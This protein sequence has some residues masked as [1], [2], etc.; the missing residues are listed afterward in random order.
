LFN[1][2]TVHGI[3]G[4]RGLRHPA[5]I[6]LLIASVLTTLMGYGSWFFLV[7]WLASSSDATGVEAEARR[8][9]LW[10]E[11]TWGAILENR[12]SQITFSALG[13]EAPLNAKKA[14]DPTGEKKGRLRDAVAVRLPE[15]E[16]RSGGSTSVDI[17]LKGVDKAYGMVRLA[18]QT[19]I[20]FD[21]MLFVGD[22]LDTGGNDYPV[23]ALGVPCRA[24]TGWEDT[25]D[26]VTALA[27]RIA[28]DR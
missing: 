5:E 28:R 1:G 14:W 22:R 12:G 6:P 10:E 4:I 3:P 9:G 25:A 8:L 13:Q 24:V 27:A 7:S 15:F 26:Y 19:G 16:V 18:E 21:A 11:R 23:K 2:A 17:T 20:P